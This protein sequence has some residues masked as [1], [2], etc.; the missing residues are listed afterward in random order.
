MEKVIAATII[1][2]IVLSIT[3]GM[4]WYINWLVENDMD[5]L[6]TTLCPIVFLLWLLLVLAL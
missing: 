4:V 5:N 2:F 1:L 6:F 3:F